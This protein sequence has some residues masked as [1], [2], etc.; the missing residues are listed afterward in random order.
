VNFEVDPFFYRERIR[1]NGLLFYLPWF[2]S[3][4][5]VYCCLESSELCCRWNTECLE[6]D[7]WKSGI[8]VS[9]IFAIVFGVKESPNYRICRSHN[10]YYNCIGDHSDRYRS[11]PV[12]LVFLKVL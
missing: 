8:V 2:L 9:L 6:I 10:L 12:S 7:T 4:R 5:Q 11:T 3:F 1:R